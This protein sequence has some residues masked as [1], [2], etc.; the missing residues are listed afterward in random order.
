MLEHRGFKLKEAVTQPVDVTTVRVVLNSG[1]L[2]WRSEDSRYSEAGHTNLDKLIRC[3]FILG[4]NRELVVRQMGTWA[5]T[6]FLYTPPRIYFRPAEQRLLRSALKGSTDQE[7]SNELGLSL[8]FVKK[9]WHSIY[10]RA[11]ETVPELH[12]DRTDGSVSQRG[13]EKKQRVL[14]YVR[15]HPEELRPSSPRS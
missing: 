5:S 3:P 2:L 6:L 9:T 1:A 10:E 11:G 12:L 4:M 13:K 8:S 14:A 7:L 15:N